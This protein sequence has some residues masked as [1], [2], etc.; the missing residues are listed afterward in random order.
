[1]VAAFALPTMAQNFEAQQPNAAFQSTSTMQSS[2]S[3][4]S[5]S[6][7]AVGSYSPSQAPAAGPRK[8]PPG[9][10]VGE[11][12]NE[13]FDNP[14][15]FPLGDALIPLLLMAILFAGITYL[16]NKRKRETQA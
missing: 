7:Y 2:G 4:Y 8:A 15:L 14:Q 6:V 9:D 5:S 3:A 12:T 13:T 10:G 1:M 16:R 11:E